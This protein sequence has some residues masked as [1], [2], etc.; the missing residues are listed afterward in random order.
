MANNTMTTQKASQVGR[1]EIASFAHLSRTN[2]GIVVGSLP[3]V[4]QVGPTSSSLMD[5]PEAGRYTSRVGLH[6]RQEP[7]F[8][9]WC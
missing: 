9:L 1:M 5:V 2:A 7:R 8:A 4:N 6:G 3:F